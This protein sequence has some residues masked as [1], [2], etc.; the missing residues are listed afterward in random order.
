MASE[1]V[2]K[3]YEVVQNHNTTTKK[4]SKAKD[5]FIKQAKTKK[6]HDHKWKH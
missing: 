3:P 4:A 2:S 6:A 1:P 5:A